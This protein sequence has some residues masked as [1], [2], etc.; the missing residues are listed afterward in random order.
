MGPSRLKD[1]HEGMGGEN[2][3]WEHVRQGGSA[4]LSIDNLG[5]GLKSWARG[6]YI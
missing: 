6:I 2:E 5:K 4:N 1:S 3:P